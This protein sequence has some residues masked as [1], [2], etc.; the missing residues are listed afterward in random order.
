M[1]QQSRK[2]LYRPCAREC[3]PGAFDQMHKSKIA[4]ML[5]IGVIEGFDLVRVDHQNR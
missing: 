4:R 5:A 3:P 2:F 1:W